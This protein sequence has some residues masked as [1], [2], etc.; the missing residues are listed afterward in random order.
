MK[1]DNL[2]YLNHILDSIKRIEE[3]VKGKAR[4]PQFATIKSNKNNFWK[5]KTFSEGLE[6]IKKQ[7]K[8]KRFKCRRYC[9]IK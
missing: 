1:K 5:M 6:E 2:I 3:Y 9:R 7:L 8:E 4:L